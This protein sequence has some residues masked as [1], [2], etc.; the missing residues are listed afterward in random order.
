MGT[1]RDIVADYYDVFNNEVKR[2]MEPRI[3]Y[4]LKGSHIHV[5][6]KVKSLEESQREEE[7]EEEE[8]KEEEEDEDNEESELSST[9]QD[10][11]N[12]DESSDESD[13]NDDNQPSDS[14]SD[15]RYVTAEESADEKEAGS[16]GSRNFTLGTFWSSREKSM[17]FRC[18]S[19][20]SIHRLDEWHVKLPSKSKF[21]ILLYHKVLKDNLLE[22]QRR[23]LVGNLVANEDFPIAY[24]MDEF[25]LEWEEFMSRQVRIEYERPMSGNLEEGEGEEEDDEEEE[26]EEE[27]EEDDEGEEQGE[28]EDE[29]EDEEEDEQGE[30]KEEELISI[31]NWNKRWRAIYCKTGIEELRPLSS[32][33]LPY[34][35]ESF[36]LLTKCAKA[37]TKRLLWF[38]ILQDLEKLSVSRR[39]LFPD[40]PLAKNDDLV[41]H[42]S[43]EQLP[44]VI[45][46][47]SVLKALNTLKQEGYYTPTI[48]ETILRTLEKFQVEPK[49]KGK[50]FR[51][52]QITMSL[53]PSLLQQG[54]LDSLPLHLPNSDPSSP[55][56]H[57]PN[58]IHKKLYT[59]QH[60]KRRKMNDSF[61]EDDPFD[62]IENPLEID[63]CDWE[64]QLLDA[65][66]L[67]LSKL[68][69][70]MLLTYY[71]PAKISSNIQLES[72]SPDQA[73]EPCPIDKMPSTL[74]NLFM[75]SNT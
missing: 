46:H 67:K 51:N 7:E 23:N 45:T 32:E 22:L 34:S 1:K 68:H 35:E 29:E 56:E 8:E 43:D 50:L 59:I 62:S 30:G 2:F 73:Q 38:T 6:S 69:Q 9:G 5:D 20:Y 28:V 61:I 52:H 18:L 13:E 49:P 37:Y 55:V 3:D 40:A 47:S 60:G 10:S 24:E 53:L 4:D 27:K 14:E 25:Y 41:L 26:E 44:H 16:N 17:F 31:E 12:D 15:S 48:P 75:H 58:M 74:L 36:E 11:A 71:N 72:E 70:H 21:D 54:S 39:S 66:D 33:P 57:E 42:A 65:K 63:L 19:R 64:A